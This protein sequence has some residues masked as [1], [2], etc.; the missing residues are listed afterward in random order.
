[1]LPWLGDVFAVPHGVPFANV[2][3]V[4]DV[5]VVA[6]AAWLVRSATHRPRHRASVPVPR[7]ELLPHRVDVLPGLPTAAA[8]AADPGGASPV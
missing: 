4:G 3:S 7:R 2:F 8:A 5:L 1:V 6:G